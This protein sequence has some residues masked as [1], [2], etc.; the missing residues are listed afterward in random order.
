MKAHILFSK[1][2]AKKQASTFITLDAPAMPKLPE[3]EQAMLKNLKL[4]AEQ[5]TALRE[6]VRKSAMLP[7]LSL[8]FD[9]DRD[10]DTSKRR[11]P[12]KE[13]IL[14]RGGVDLGFSL[15]ATFDLPKLLFNSAELDVE[16]LSLKRLEKREKSIAHLHELYFRYIK[17]LE[18]GKKPNDTQN[19]DELNAKMKE[20]AAAIDSMSAGAFTLLQSEVK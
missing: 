13:E 4:G 1:G 5:E 19:I 6:R 9:V 17:L 11:R 3:L 15:R 2:I 12:N 7:Q 8:I 20:I 14:E 10:E 16:T 18:E